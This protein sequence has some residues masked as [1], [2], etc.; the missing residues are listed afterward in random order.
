MLEEKLA[1]ISSAYSGIQLQ[2]PAQFLSNFQF[3]I[4]DP[5]AQHLQF[6]VF[7]QDDL[8]EDDFL[9]RYVN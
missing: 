6:M 3:I 7:D 5:V 1:Q 9:G 4:L 8:N 2:T